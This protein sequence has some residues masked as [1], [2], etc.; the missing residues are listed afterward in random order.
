L[1]TYKIPLEQIERGLQLCHDNAQDFWLTGRIAAQN[2]SLNVAL[3]L[4]IYALEEIG[5]FT[6]LREASEGRDTSEVIIE[7]RVFKNHRV[8]LE[9]AISQFK[10]WGIPLR[11]LMIVLTQEERQRLWFVS[12]DE[13][14]REFKREYTPGLGNIGQ[15]DEFVMVGLNAMNTMLKKRIAA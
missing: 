15:L 11:Q 12:W 14:A 5:K 4:Y 13:K 7:E 2:G 8:K 1:V 10:A 3:G 9:K 6:L